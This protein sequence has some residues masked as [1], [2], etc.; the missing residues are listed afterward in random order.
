MLD[1][2]TGFALAVNDLVVTSEK[3]WL[4]RPYALV[5]ELGVYFFGFLS[6]LR[7]ESARSNTK[8]I[9]YCHG[10]TGSTLLVDLLN[11]HPCVHCDREV[12]ALPSLFTQ[13]FLN[14]KRAN[15]SELAFGCKILNHQLMR[16]VG[17]AE[18]HDFLQELRADGWK[19][20]YLVRDNTVRHALSFMA[21]R[22]RPKRHRKVAD[23]SFSQATFY[24]ETKELQRRMENLRHERLRDD[25]LLSEVDHLCLV[26]ERDLLDG[27][28]H[29]ETANRV[30]AYVGLEPAE[31]RTRLA[32]TTSD[33]LADFIAN[34]DEVEAFEQSSHFAT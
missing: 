18:I 12:L 14:A 19:V 25:A 8:F 34:A 33:S 22:H 20:I 21:M 6:R 1:R 3:S 13:K 24:V 4:L 26:Y 27:L 9:I 17:Q 31:V 28:R 11:A 5:R 32:R 23:R 10:R 29:Q 2:L 30:F 15:Y 7:R 16:Q